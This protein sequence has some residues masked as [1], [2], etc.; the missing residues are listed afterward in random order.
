LALNISVG[1]PAKQFN[2]SIETA[3]SRMWLID[4][5]LAGQTAAKNVYDP[6]KSKKSVK[7]DGDFEGTSGPYMITGDLY[8]D[9][10]N[11]NGEFDFDQDFGSVFSFGLGPINKYPLD[12][13]LG[14][15]WNASNLQWGETSSPIINLL[16]P[17]DKRWIT[18]W[19]GP[20]LVPSEGISKYEITLGATDNK[21][22]DKG[23]HFVPLTEFNGMTSVLAVT[24]DS[25][26]FGTFKSDPNELATTDTGFPVIQVGASEFI[27][28]GK[29]T[30][31]VY[32]FD[33]ELLTVL[34]DSVSTFNDLVF[35]IKG[36]DYS[37]PASNYVVDM[38]MG[39]G[40]CA[41]AI[42][43]NQDTSDFPSIVLGNP[44]MRF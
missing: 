39:G 19:I 16:E 23:L 13:A 25:F 40:F 43:M 30:K 42:G 24:V 35:T 29:Q 28:I 31:A 9:S 8:K 34:C 3:T 20:H 32:D 12:G 36:V 22:C 11:L 18:I 2:V 33:L 14:L 10:V 27:E 4:S 17:C 15:Q 38:D 37:V 1:S 7:K 26:S 5:G 6:T 41:L 44:F 21:H